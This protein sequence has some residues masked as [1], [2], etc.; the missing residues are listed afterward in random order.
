MIGSLAA[1]PKQVLQV[2]SGCGRRGALPPP[3]TAAALMRFGMQD[4]ILLCDT[5]SWLDSLHRRWGK[6]HAARSGQ[7]RAWHHV[8]RVAKIR[9]DLRL[10]VTRE[11]VSDDGRCAHQPGWVPVGYRS[12]GNSWRSPLDAK[13]PIHDN[14][15]RPSAVNSATKRA[16]KT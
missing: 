16:R 7:K 15:L 4:V 1:R 13:V 6:M 11:R 14:A 3:T 9:E 5:F 12:D 10:L 2:A 8:F